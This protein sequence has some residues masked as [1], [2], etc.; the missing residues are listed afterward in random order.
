MNPVVGDL[1]KNASKIIALCEQEKSSDM[2]VFPEL[3]ICGYPPEDLLHQADFL[4]QCAAQIQQIAKAVPQDL[5]VIVGAPI[6]V[7]GDCYNMALALQGGR[8][9]AQYA[10][11]HLPNYGVFDEARYFVAGTQA[12]LIEVKGWQCALT[13]CEDLWHEDVALQ[14]KAE[15]ADMLINLNASPYCQGKPEA[16][17]MTMAR[18]A[19]GLPLVYVNQVG[20]QDELVF[21]GNSFVMN[22]Q[23]EK[24][25]SLPAFKEANTAIDLAALPTAEI[26]QAVDPMAVIYRALVLGTQDYVRKNGFT[27]VVLG[28]SG[29]IDSALTLCVAVDALGADNV[30]V[31]MMPSRYNLEMSLEDAKIQAKKLGVSSRVVSIEPMF[32]AF[33]NS[34]DFLKGEPASV[35]QENIQARIRGVIL[36]ARSNQ[37]GAMLLTTGNK[38]ELSVG[39][40]TLYGDMAGGF[41]PLKDVYKTLV[42]DLSRWLNRE[43]EIIPNRVIVRPPSAELSFDQKDSDSLPDYPVLDRILQ[44][45]IEDRKGVQAIGKLIQDEA[46]AQKIVAMVDRNEYKRCQAPP[47]VRI[48]SRAYGKDRRYPITNQFG[49]K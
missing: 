25:V 19:A 29:G 33:L 1:T 34:V 12:V 36:M 45:Y 4:A 24:V 28:L 7:S 39:Y 46:L 42:F 31:I 43:Q 37:T 8:I 41:A 40:A 27:K 44:L 6:V 35:T 38:S 15:G 13:V 26:A 17:E 48:T 14:A 30:E 23:G 16:R 49:V 3:C 11:Q 10:K 18:H 2:M 20:G 47:G 9:I 32:D 21:D 5:V 22:A